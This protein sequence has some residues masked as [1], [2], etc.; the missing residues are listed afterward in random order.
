MRNKRRLLEMSGI[1]HRSDILTEQDDL[2]GDDEC[3][4]FLDIDMTGFDLGQ[5]QQVVNHVQ[6]EG[7]ELTREAAHPTALQMPIQ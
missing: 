4:H 3:I 7:D 1:I 5:I 2:F 6:A